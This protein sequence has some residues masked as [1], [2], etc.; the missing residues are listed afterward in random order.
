MKQ[1]WASV[2][3]LQRVPETCRIAGLP[4]NSVKMSVFVSKASVPTS[5]AYLVTV[6]PYDTAQ[7]N[8]YIAINAG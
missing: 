4:H 5:P 6:N 3:Q 1:S 2:L 8:A 7:K